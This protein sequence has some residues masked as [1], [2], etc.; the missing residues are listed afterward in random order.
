M[1]R[2]ALFLPAVV[3]YTKRIVCLAKSTKLGATC[4]A[5][6]EWSEGAAGEWIRPIGNRPSEAI[7]DDELTLDSGEAISLLDIVEIDFVAHRPHSCQVENHLI[8]S[9]SRWRRVSRLRPSQ[10]GKLAE[11]PPTIWGASGLG[12]IND[13]VPQAEADGF[14][15]SLV[16]V[17]LTSPRV[18]VKKWPERWTVRVQFDYQG[19]LYNLTVTD[20]DFE[21]RFKALGV[22]T[23]SL[24]A[25]SY[26]CVSL[27]EPYEGNRHKLAAAVFEVE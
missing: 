7:S 8:D 11:T 9:S 19:E 18:E 17:R 6:R 4:V 14:D 1:S 24:S 3:T 2:V 15:S 27:G 16:L 12:Y 25:K 5:G 10:L 26:A 20:P 23:H 22:G 21:S 13:R